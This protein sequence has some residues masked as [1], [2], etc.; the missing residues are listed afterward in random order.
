MRAAKIAIFFLLFSAAGLAQQSSANPVTIS[1]C[2]ISVNG[3]FTLRTPQGERFI[4]K[5]DHDTLFSYNGKQVQITG[6]PKSTKKGSST[7]KSGE[8]HVSSF[9]KLADVCQ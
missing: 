9:K 2:L 7:P 4:L 5:G 8:F 1:G 3:A 6:T